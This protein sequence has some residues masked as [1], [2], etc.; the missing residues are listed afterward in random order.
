MGIRVAQG[1]FF[2]LLLFISGF[3]TAMTITT[4]CVEHGGTIRTASLDICKEK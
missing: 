3:S 4:S 2:A 1:L